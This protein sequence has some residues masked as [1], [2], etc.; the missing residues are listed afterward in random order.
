MQA[1][2]GGI[3]I[4]PDQGDVR[5]VRAQDAAPGCRA[6]LWVDKDIAAC[7]VAQGRVQFAQVETRFGG[8]MQDDE[9][10]GKKSGEVPELPGDD[11]RLGMH[12]KRDVDQNRSRPVVSSAWY[13]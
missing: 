9:G 8:N 1:D 12:R 13:S 6:A 7:P 3:A 11:R 2:P 5:Q 4:P 10:L